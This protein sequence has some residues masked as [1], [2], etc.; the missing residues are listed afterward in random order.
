MSPGQVIT[1]ADGQKM[2]MGADGQLSP[3]GGT[4]N[5]SLGFGAGTAGQSPGVQVV[6]GPAVLDSQEKRKLIKEIKEEIKPKISQIA[7][8]Q[9]NKA[10]EIIKIN[11]RKL[12]QEMQHENEKL[13]AKIAR[14]I[15]STVEKAQVELKHVERDIKENIRSFQRQRARDKSD[16]D[17]MFRA[18]VEDIK[19]HS[20]KL[21]EY[22]VNFEAL[23]IVNSMLV[24][25]INMQMEG[26]IADLLDRRM[27]SL[28]GVQQKK[29][30]K[31]DV[32]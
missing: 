29:A 23:A 27:M 25:N 7:D 11:I 8:F 24:E 2:I 12:E 3:V 31:L 32:Q 26:E 9:I 1:T 28:F 10:N 13:H 22:A 17:I 18:Q 20:A 19:N 5:S 14:E 30:T 16:Q 15:K 21:E 6:A 4:A